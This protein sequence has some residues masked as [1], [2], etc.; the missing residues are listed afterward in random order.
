MAPKWHTTLA[1]V[2]RSLYG[3]P[4]IMAEKMIS[5]NLPQLSSKV[6]RGL[7]FVNKHHSMPCLALP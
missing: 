6:D 7:H 4:N 1:L 5:M 2:G 3:K